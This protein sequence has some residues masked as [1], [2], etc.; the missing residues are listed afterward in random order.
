MKKDKVSVP[1]N[2]HMQKRLLLLNLNELYSSFKSEYPNIKVG[3]SKFCVLRP[4]WCVL[5]GSSGT[6][7][8]CVCMIHQNVIL[9]LQASNIEETYKELI[10]Y[11]VCCINNKDYMERH[12]EICLL[13]ENFKKFL[14]E[15][16]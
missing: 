8:V 15:K 16:F 10:Q 11:L 4:K 9:L 5:A 7:S 6:H 12:N 1:T 14:N 3:F 13:K 2:V